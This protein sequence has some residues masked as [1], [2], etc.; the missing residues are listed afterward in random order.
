MPPA[1]GLLSITTVW[2]SFC[3]ST[4]VNGRMLLSAALPGENG[5]IMVIVRF[6]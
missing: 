2:P 1:P 5:T 4:R 3:D 6:G